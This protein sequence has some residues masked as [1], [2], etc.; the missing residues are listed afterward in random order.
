MLYL[1]SVPKVHSPHPSQV[2]GSFINEGVREMM[3]FASGQRYQ[4]DGGLRC[5]IV[6]VTPDQEDVVLVVEPEGT[7]PPKLAL[8]IQP[9]GGGPQYIVMASEL[10]ELHA[11]LVH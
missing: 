7:V 2:C 11:E 9:I 6:S 4:V 3:S 8:M 5:R 10:H 1:S